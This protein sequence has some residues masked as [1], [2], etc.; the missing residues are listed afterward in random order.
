MQS[1]ITEGTLLILREETAFT[2]PTFVDTPLHYYHTSMKDIHTIHGNESILQIH[3]LDDKPGT[4]DYAT[5][6]GISI[7][8]NATY[9]PDMTDPSTFQ[10]SL[11]SNA[12]NI[13]FIWTQTTHSSKQ[14]DCD[15]FSLEN[16]FVLI[17][18]TQMTR[19]VLHENFLQDM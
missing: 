15:V 2:D 8:I 13:H 10:L 1:D 3:Y 5:I 12:A 7:E 19:K 11:S 17:G 14:P 6:D 18:K 9:I 4:I 16:V